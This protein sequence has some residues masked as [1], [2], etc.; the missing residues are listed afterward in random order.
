MTHRIEAAWLQDADL[1]ALLAALGS[2]GEEARIVGGAI[3]NHLL[4]QPITDVDIATTAVPQETIRRGQ[5]AG[6]KAVATGIEHGTVTMVR[7]S[8]AFEVT[9]LRF[10][11]EPDGRRARVVF[12]RDW[13]VDAQRRDFTINALYADASGTIYD[14]VG[15]LADI[16]SGTLRFI[17][18]AADRINED[19][20]RSLRFYRFFAWYGQGRPDADAIRATARLKGELN[21]LS[22]ERVW[23]ELKKLLAAPDPSRALLWMRQA[24]VLSTILP[25]SDKWGIDAVHPLIE[26]ERHFGWQADPLLRLMAIVPPDSQRLDALAKRLRFSKAEKNRLVEFAELGTLPANLSETAFQAKLYDGERQAL[27]DRLQLDIAAMRA[28]LVQDPQALAML[29]QLVHRLEQAQSFV[30]ASFPLSGADL[31]AAGV[32][33]GPQLGILMGQLR[34]SWIESGF[35][36]QKSALLEKLDRLIAAANKQ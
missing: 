34:H 25:E 23:A 12:G 26:A 6:F 35:A 29:P 22:A 10:D 28:K 11:A 33:A 1:Q 4:G 8:R 3:R 20:L 15:G 13:T 18:E 21:G 27:Q 7:N 24:G 31:M 16:E 2:D 36:L 19:H 32:P 14:P 30:P 17:G 5:A 9:T